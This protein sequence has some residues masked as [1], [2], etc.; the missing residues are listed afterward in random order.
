MK[1]RNIFLSIEQAARLWR[2][3]NSR[4][5]MAVLLFAPALLAACVRPPSAERVGATPACCARTNSTQAATTAPSFSDRSLFQLESSWTNDAG[6]AVKL[7][8]LAG[9]PLLVTMFFARCEYACPVL[10]HDMKVVEAALPADVRARMGFVLVTIDPERDTP[11]ALANYRRIHA[12]PANWTLLRGGSDDILELAALLGVKY[13]RDA[14]GQFA[15]SNLLTVLSP[16]GEL[17]HQQV[18]LHQA[19]DITVRQLVKLVED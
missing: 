11:E 6:A 19:P 12:L 14:R 3:P 13:K 2:W 17:V 8:A 18:G 4:S 10:V 7:Q 1:I 15:H 9:R 5:T 16:D